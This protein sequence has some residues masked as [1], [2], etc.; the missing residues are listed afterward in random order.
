MFIRAYIFLYRGDAVTSSSSIIH[1]CL[2]REILLEFCA[3]VFSLVRRIFSNRKS[4]FFNFRTYSVFYQCSLVNTFRK[5]RERNEK[6]REKG[7]EMWD[8]G[9]VCGKAA[10]NLKTKSGWRRC[11]RKRCESSRGTFSAK[12]IDGD[13]KVNQWRKTRYGKN[14]LVGHTSGKDRSREWETPKITIDRG[15][16]DDDSKPFPRAFSPRLS[17]YLSHAFYRLPI[18]FSLALFTM[19]NRHRYRGSDNLW[20]LYC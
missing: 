12:P 13:A 14:E 16:V 6:R 8:E 15:S 17:L 7:E 9:K 3:T 4:K 20:L 1:N 10:C 5:Q 2:E 19:Y 18:V 11:Q